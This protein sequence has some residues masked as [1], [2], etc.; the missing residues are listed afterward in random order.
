MSPDVLIR[1]DFIFRDMSQIPHYTATG[2]GTGSAE[3][4]SIATSTLIAL[5]Q[6]SSMQA[7]AA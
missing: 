1:L 7:S 3:K 4:R 5:G 6:E 2:S